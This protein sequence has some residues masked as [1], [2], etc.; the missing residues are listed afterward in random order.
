MINVSSETMLSKFHNLISYS[1]L[2]SPETPTHQRHVEDTLPNRSNNYSTDLAWGVIPMDSTQPIKGSYR[3]PSE[4]L[5]WN[6]KG[7]YFSPKLYPFLHFLNILKRLFIARKEVVKNDCVVQL[8]TIFIIRAFQTRKWFSS[9]NRTK[10]YQRMSHTWPTLT[11]N[12]TKRQLRF[13]FTPLTT[14]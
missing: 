7:R 2:N 12:I 5:Q 11:I 8:Q 10:F 1:C 6:K 14:V 9:Q 4:R 13:P 3:L